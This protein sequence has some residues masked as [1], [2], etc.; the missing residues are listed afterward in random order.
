[1]EKV[2]VGK[3]KMGELT[4]E[5]QVR[6]AAAELSRVPGFKASKGWFCNFCAKHGVVAGV[7]G[8]QTVALLL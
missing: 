7:S 3:I 5:K 2:L 8:R 6:E 4:D 1:M